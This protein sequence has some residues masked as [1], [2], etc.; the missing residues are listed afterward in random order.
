MV[1]LIVLV[2]LRDLREW[3]QFVADRKA[4][5]TEIET[6]V[7]VTDTPQNYRFSTFDN[8]LYIA[9]TTQVIVPKFE[10]PPQ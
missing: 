1:T 4:A 5:E 3:K 2:N 8:A 10:E 7:P 9:A 6:D